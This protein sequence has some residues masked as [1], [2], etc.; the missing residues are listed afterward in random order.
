MLSEQAQLRVVT[1]QLHCCDGAGQLCSWSWVSHSLLRLLTVEALGLILP[2]LHASSTNSCA[3]LGSLPILHQCLHR[4]VMSWADT[5][6]E[7][8]NP[9]PVLQRNSMGIEN[10]VDDSSGLAFSPGHLRVWGPLLSCTNACI[11]NKCC[12]TCNQRSWLCLDAC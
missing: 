1:V 7:E 6:R 10:C 11:K 4:I 8:Q 3:S 12:I 5:S 9:G 2:S